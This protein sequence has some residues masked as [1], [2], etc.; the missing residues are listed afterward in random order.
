MIDQIED[1]S[2]HKNGHIYNLSQLCTT[3]STMHTSICIRFQSNFQ[4]YQLI[5]G[6]RKLPHCCKL[7]GKEA[8]SA[9]PAISNPLNS[10]IIIVPLPWPVVYTGTCKLA[11]EPV[12]GGICCGKN[13]GCVGLHTPSY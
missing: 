4:A 11:K 3:L 5:Y 10:S 9:T 12:H 6:S 8:G 7:A 1:N 2:L 13:W